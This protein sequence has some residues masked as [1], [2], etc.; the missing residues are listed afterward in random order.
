[1][2]SLS[3]VSP[4]PVRGQLLPLPRQPSQIYVAVRGPLPI[5]LLETPL[6][7]TW[8]S[9]K[10]S[11]AL[12]TLAFSTVFPFVSSSMC[13]SL[14]S[15]FGYLLNKYSD[16][17]HQWR[18]N[19]QIHWVLFGANHGDAL[20][21]AIGPAISFLKLSSFGLYGTT[22]PGVCPFTLP[23]LFSQFSPSDPLPVAHP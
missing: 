13:H 20:L 15:A 14:I 18:P 3:P 4:S 1:M 5:L 2:P 16:N 9:F 6:S 17:H 8:F 11:K 7:W 12:W 10:T 22:F 19:R 23:T 21:H